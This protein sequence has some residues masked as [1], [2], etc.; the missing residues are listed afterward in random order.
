MNVIRQH[1]D[2]ALRL[3]LC[4]AG[5]RASVR[6]SKPKGNRKRSPFPSV[7]ATDGP[8][9][10]ARALS[11]SANVSYPFTSK[12]LQ[13]LHDAGIVVSSM[14]PRGGFALAR[15]ADQI[16]LRQVIDTVQGPLT[17]NNCPILQGG[18]SQPNCPI[19]RI[20]SDLQKNLQQRLDEVTL[21][22]ILKTG[23]SYKRDCRKLGE[24]K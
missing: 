4:L 23:R 3:L 21:A 18:C 5:R 1:T 7:S 8:V 24:S 9:A 13:T 6:S 17:V 22:D 2:Y 12:I 15:S 14:G 10:S 19:S 11:R 20:M 16:T